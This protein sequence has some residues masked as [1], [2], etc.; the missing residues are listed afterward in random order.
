MSSPSGILKGIMPFRAYK[1]GVR[2][3]LVSGTIIR[4][5]SLPSLEEMSVK[6]DILPKALG[7][8]PEQLLQR[9]TSGELVFITINGLSLKPYKDRNGMEKISVKASSIT[10]LSKEDDDEIIV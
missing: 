2:S 4:V 9:N 8:S 3:E 5:L 7:I 10:I 6:L 1:D